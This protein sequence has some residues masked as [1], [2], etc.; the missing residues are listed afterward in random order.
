MLRIWLNLNTNHGIIY[1]GTC[2]GNY[3]KDSG[4]CEPGGRTPERNTDHKGRD[5]NWLLFKHAVASD[6][7]NAS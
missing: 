4:L 5:N 6:P 7:H 2:P 1:V 3:C